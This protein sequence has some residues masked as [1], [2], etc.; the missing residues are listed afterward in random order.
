MLQS[1]HLDLTQVTTYKL[2]SLLL[3]SHFMRIIFNI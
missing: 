1:S 3:N 2:I